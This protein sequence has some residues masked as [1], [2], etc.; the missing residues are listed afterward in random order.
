MSEHGQALS[1]LLRHS[2]RVDGAGWASAETAR[3]FL[4]VSQVILEARTM[5]LPCTRFAKHSTGLWKPLDMDCLKR[6]CVSNPWVYGTGFGFGR[7]LGGPPFLVL[8]QRQPPAP[9]A[10]EGR[11]GG[12]SN[13]TPSPH[14][15]IGDRPQCGSG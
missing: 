1:W 13:R 6:L 14:G 7:C 11:W 15:A 2:G 12:A 4:N 8:P 3:G 9:P 10:P 5:S